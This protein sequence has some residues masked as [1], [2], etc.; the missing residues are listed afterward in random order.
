MSQ[1][2]GAVYFQDD[3][4]LR[5]ELTVSGGI[6]VEAQQ[7]ISG[8]HPGPR[9]GIAWSPFRDGKTTIRAG[10]GVFF[11]WFDAQTYEQA[12]Q[13][14]GTHQRIATIDLSRISESM[15]AARTRRCCRR[16]GCELAPD[17]VA[18]RPARSERADR[19]SAARQLS[20]KC[21]VR[22]AARRE[23]SAR[24][25]TSTRR[26]RTASVL[27]HW[28][29]RSP[30]S[31]RLRL[32]RSTRCSSISIIRDPNGASSSALNYA[33]ARSINDTDGVFNLPADSH[34]LAA[35]RGP[36]ADRRTPPIHQP[37][38]FSAVQAS[39]RSARRSVCSRRCR[40][41]SPPASTR[42]TTPSAT[43]VRRASRATPVAAARSSMSASRL[44]WTVGFGGAP[45]TGPGGPQVAI[46]RGGDADPLAQHAVRR[47]RDSRY[48]V[49]L[50]L[51]GYNLT[52][53]TNATEL[54]RRG[55]VT[56]FRPGD[57]G[58]CGAAPRTRRAAGFLRV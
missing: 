22:G 15:R 33:L 17:L 53:H 46:I 4:R 8:V 10:A 11:D 16:A 9:G 28:P 50:Y 21:H 1:W 34:N 29:A 43:I 24:A 23:H 48:R 2:Q 40:T 49:E 13:L 27:I 32:R 55:D 38:E 52:N 18:A 41:T 56:V 37:R 42:T 58:I 3:Y 35:E 54:Q 12:V 39:S 25:S 14:D 45:R 31:S 7:H 44:T 30:V 26:S 19:T 20:R 51:Q 47:Q 57:S 5:R 36:A 6:R